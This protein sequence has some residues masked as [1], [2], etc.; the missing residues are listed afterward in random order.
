MP[1]RPSGTVY[2]RRGIWF[3]RIPGVER[4]QRLAAC[5]TKDQASARK[6]IMFATATRLR[7]SVHSDMVTNFVEQMAAADEGRLKIVLKLVDGLLDGREHRKLEESVAKSTTLQQ[8]GEQWTSGDLHR[9]YP[10]HVKDIDHHDNKSRL[11]RHVY[12]VVGHIYMHAFNVDHGDLVLA[13]PT[14]PSGSHR[15]V[16]SV[17]HRLVVL[18]VY[19]GRLLGLNPLPT[20]WVPKPAKQKAR[21]WIYPSEDAKLMT[22]PEVPLVRRLLEGFLCRE[23]LRASE[24]ARLEWAD[25]DLDHPNG[26]GSINLDE[27]KTDDPRAWALDR[28]VAEAL[29]RWKEIA[30]ESAYVFPA[31]AMPRSRLRGRHMYTDDLAEKLRADLAAAGVTR[32][33]LFNS[34]DKRMRLRA[35][36]E[37]ATFVTISLANG[38]TETWVQD[39]TGH[40]SSTMISTYRRQARQAAELDL[41]PLKPLFLAIPELAA[42]GPGTWDATNARVAD[43]EPA[44]D[45]EE[46][47]PD[48]MIH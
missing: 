13:Q 2:E 24:A 31:E 23:G 20:G 16:A 7:V 5:F 17:L 46:R 15:H 11:E 36:D 21:G 37:R 4:D 39:R 26:N 8:F 22:C 12:P 27:N 6:E 18:A 19:P 32:P 9:R 25:L 43:P 30:P 42:K 3:A 10:T 40:K 14:I 34:T 44:E 33:A 35:H 38:K 41:G 28:G 47:A 48:P 45:D 29:R 1:R